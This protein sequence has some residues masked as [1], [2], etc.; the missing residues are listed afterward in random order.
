M[1]EESKQDE[2]GLQAMIDERESER[3]RMRE[4]V[5]RLKMAIFEA[6]GVP[7]LV[8]NLTQILRKIKR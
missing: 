2:A 1:S 6:L 8:N 3:A 7:L 4:A 5:H